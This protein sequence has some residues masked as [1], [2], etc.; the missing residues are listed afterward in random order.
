MTLVSDL[1]LNTNC[2]LFKPV[3]K[4][5]QAIENSMKGVIVI[6]CICG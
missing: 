4:L 3:V 5:S 2:R 1:M 6:T